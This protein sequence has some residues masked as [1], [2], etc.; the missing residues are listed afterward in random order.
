MRN[1]ALAV[2]LCAV[3]LIAIAPRPARAYERPDAVSL[4]GQWELCTV[5]PA[6]DIVDPQYRQ[7]V[8]DFPRPD[9][10]TL[11]PSL[12]Q[13]VPQRI[14]PPRDAQ[15]QP[16]TVPGAWELAAGID[17]NGAGWYRRTVDIPAEWLAG[18]TA[19]SAVDP[20]GGAGVPPADAS[21]G[22]G[23]PARDPLAGK[24]ARPT[25]NASVFD[26]TSIGGGSPGMAITGGAADGS[27]AGSAAGPASARRI[28]LEFDAV[29]CA[30]GVWL[31]GKWCGGHVGDFSRWRVELTSA[32]KPGANE[33]WVYVD[34][35]PGHVTQGFLCIIMPHHG[36]IWQ[37]VRMYS[38]GPVSIEPDGVWI[39]ANPADGSFIAEVR[40]S[41]A[42]PEAKRCSRLDGHYTRLQR[43][44]R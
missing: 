27:P 41:D 2:L 20:S 18:S 1:S 40:L 21:G 15:W 23:A 25:G 29:S 7:A 36:G 17:Y 11:A 12:D 33:L 3:C 31:N 43:A 32:A 24:G 8:Q 4:A 28:W 14:C 10:P 37:D 38:T 39:K 9:F 35:L 19:V 5:A 6:V 44:R 16:V 26:L 13:V 22:A 42:W 34:E 30:A